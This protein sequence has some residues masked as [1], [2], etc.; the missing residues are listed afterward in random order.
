MY[1][2]PILLASIPFQPSHQSFFST[3]ESSRAPPA[4]RCHLPLLIPWTKCLESGDS[5]MYPYQRTPMGNPYIKPY[6][7]WVFMDCNPQESLENATNTMSTL[8]GKPP[9]CPLMELRG[10]LLEESQ[11]PKVMVIWLVSLLE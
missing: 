1:N 5:W 4:N 3:K 2:P 8:L 11:V 9:N 6:I 10:E 7:T